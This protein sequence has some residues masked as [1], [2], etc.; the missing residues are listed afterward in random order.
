MLSDNVCYGTNSDA[1]LLCTNAQAIESFDVATLQ[2]LFTQVAPNKEAYTLLSGA[3]A[4]YKAKGSGVVTNPTE[5]RDQIVALRQY[6]QNHAIKTEA[7]KIQVPYRYMVPF[8]V[9]FNRSLQNLSSY[10]T[11]IG[12]VRLLLLMLL[13][14]GF[15]YSLFH[16][17]HFIQD[18]N[19]A[20]LSGITI[21]GWVI[22]WII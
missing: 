9:V 21:I 14:L 17:K 3:L 4:T 8:N 18:N 19:I 15:V 10:Y 20:I 1:K 11:D 13:V 16:Q 7:G 6:Y 22:W 5:Y 12:F 2:N